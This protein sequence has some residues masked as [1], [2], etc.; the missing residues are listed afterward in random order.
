MADHAGLRLVTERASVSGRDLRSLP[1]T[2]SVV[3]R[4]QL[5]VVFRFL[6]PIRGDMAHRTVLFGGSILLVAR[7]AGTHPLRTVG[8]EPGVLVHLEMAGG[9][10]DF[11]GVGGMGEFDILLL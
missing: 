1:G 11:A 7:R 6:E 3:F 2:G 4:P 10:G 5:K 9:A 8:H